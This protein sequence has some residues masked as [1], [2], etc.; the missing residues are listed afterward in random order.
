MKIF[1]EVFFEILIVCIVLLVVCLVGMMKVKLVNRAIRYTKR[2]PIRRNSRRPIALALNAEYAR[3]NQAA[4]TDTAT[5]IRVPSVSFNWVLGAV[6]G[7]F[8]AFVLTKNHLRGGAQYFIEMGFD[9]HDAFCASAVALCLLGGVAGVVLAVSLLPAA[10]SAIARVI[11]R[12]RLEGGH[13]VIFGQAMGLDECIIF[14]ITRFARRHRQR[15][16]K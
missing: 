10:E 14:T 6:V 11:A 9:T 15:R 1:V 13:K 3:E 16:N 5:I 8:V 4:N 12:E 2:S 7:C